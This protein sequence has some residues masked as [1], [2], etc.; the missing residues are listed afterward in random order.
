[1]VLTCK[2]LKKISNIFIRPVF[3]GLFLLYVFIVG[4]NHLKADYHPTVIS[5]EV[6][7]LEKT[8]QY[9]VDREILHPLNSKIDTTLADLDR[10]RIFNLGL[11]DNVAW[12][13]VPL[14]NGDAKLQF[15]MIESINKTP[16]L[17][18]PSYD[19]EKGWSLN[20]CLLYTSDAADE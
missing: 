17:I 12:R 10:N 19:E 16:P 9:I 14:E 5:I 20:G 4:P 15:I 2:F 3:P 7:G 18:F 11:F 13:L 8:K 1:M 6:I